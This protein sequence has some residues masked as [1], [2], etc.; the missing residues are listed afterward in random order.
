MP[1]TDGPSDLQCMEMARFRPTDHPDILWSVT[2]TGDGDRWSKFRNW[3]RQLDCTKAQQQMEVETVSPADITPR[4]FFDKYIKLRRPVLLSGH[5]TDKA[6]AG[7]RWLDNEYLVRRAGDAP[8]KVERKAD[9]S[10]NQF[11]NGSEVNMTFRDFMDG[12]AKQ[13][14]SYYLTTQELDY[15]HE[16]RPSLLSSPVDRLVDD[17]PLIPSLMGNLVLQNANMWVGCTDKETSSGLHHDYHDNLYIVLRGA[18]RLVLFAPEHAKNLYTV[19]EIEKV[20]HNGRINYSG[21]PT[22]ADGSATASVK[23][24]HASEKIISASLRLEVC[25]VGDIR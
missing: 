20:H 4:E 3:W 14:S 1:A 12:I 8:V 6:W 10:I 24:A 18:K 11:G 5:L 22:L 13:N 19:G 2:G 16:G 17:F 9:N 25:A 15:N 7:S 21:Q 23:A